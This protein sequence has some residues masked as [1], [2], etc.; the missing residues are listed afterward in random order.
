MFTSRSNG[1]RSV[2]KCPPNLWRWA[3]CL[4]SSTITLN[5]QGILW[6]L[7]RDFPDLAAAPTATN[8][9]GVW[10]YGWKEFDGGAI[11]VL[12]IGTFHRSETLVYESGIIDWQDGGL[13]LGFGPADGGQVWKNVSGE[14]IHGIQPGEVSVNADYNRTSTI[15]FTAPTTGN[16]EIS[17]AFGWGDGG[18]GTRSV[19]WNGT[20]LWRAAGAGSFDFTGANQLVLGAGDTLDFTAWG[21]P[22][23]YGNT[24][25]LATVNLVSPVPEPQTYGVMAALG[26]AGFGIHRARRRPCASGKPPAA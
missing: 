14:M 17:G 10:S 6:D 9:N 21:H 19:F 24:P 20:E 4:L 5:A 1:P 25:V 22:G 15:R 13:G 11:G 7:V 16:Y 12:P 3:V 2:T 23:R 26:L 18:N 8:P